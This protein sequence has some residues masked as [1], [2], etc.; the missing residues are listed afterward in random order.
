MSNGDHVGAIFERSFNMV[1]GLLGIL[2][3]GAVYVPM[4]PE[5][6]LA[7]KKNITTSADIK[8]ILTDQ[9]DAKFAD[10]TVMIEAAYSTNVPCHNLNLAKSSHDL[11][12]VIYTSGSTGN[13]KGVMIAHHSAVNLIEWV[14]TRFAVNQDDSLLFITSMC[15]DLSVYDMFGAL[16]TGAKVVIATQSQVQ[17]AEELA[18]LLKDEQN[19]FLG[20]GASNNETIW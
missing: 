16:A 20:F 10:T 11:A 9:S 17:N 12:Y 18:G 2:K 8:T 6:P 15:F 4:E 19:H 1:I 14:N 13:P 5:Y 7:R 3:A